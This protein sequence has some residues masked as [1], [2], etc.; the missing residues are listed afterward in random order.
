MKSYESA[1]MPNGLSSVRYLIEMGLEGHFLYTSPLIAIRKSLK[2]NRCQEVS[3]QITQ[4]DR[5]QE[6][7]S[8]VKQSLYI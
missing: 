8:Q 2:L 5:C 6:G 4:G 7:V 3:V 1:Q